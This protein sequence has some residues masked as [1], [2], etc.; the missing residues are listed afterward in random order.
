MKVKQ[1]KGLTMMGLVFIFILIIVLIVVVISI[2]KKS[3]NN[4]NNDD[5]IGNEYIENIQENEKINTSLK[6]QEDKQYN[7]IQYTNI[8]ITQKADVVNIIM[9]ATNNSGI[10]IKESDSIIKIKLLNENGEEIMSV[11]A[12]I[13]EIKI[14]ETKQISASTILEISE[15]HDIKIEN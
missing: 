8:S 2:V 14:G 15:I 10:N 6:I 7:G 11:G 4:E 13:G 12:M 9:N 3:G 5:N 1:E